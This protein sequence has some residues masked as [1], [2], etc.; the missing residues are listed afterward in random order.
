MGRGPR[1][2]ELMRAPT[3]E[4][5]NIIHVGI[6]SVQFPHQFA[7][8]VKAPMS[9]NKQSGSWDPLDSSANAISLAGLVGLKLLHTSS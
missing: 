6:G 4:L 1:E 9:M 2:S 3:K 5:F 8:C 7:S